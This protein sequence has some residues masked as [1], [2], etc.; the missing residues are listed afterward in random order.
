MSA[1]GRLHP[2]R[3]VSMRCAHRQATWQLWNVSQGSDSCHEASFAPF[4]MQQPGPASGRPNAGLADGAGADPS[5]DVSRRAGSR[6]TSARARTGSPRSARAPTS[7]S[8]CTIY[9]R[10]N[11]T[12][13]PGSPRRASRRCRPRAGRMQLSR[14]MPLQTPLAMRT[15]RRRTARMAG[16]NCPRTA[17]DCAVREVVRALGQM[18]VNRTAQ[19]CNF[20]NATIGCMAEPAAE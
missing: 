8:A 18:A 3:G 5:A 11:R 1:V 20:C 17:S 10:A 13:P 16:M 7:L 4:C 9:R 12:T 2:T 14:R 6:G 15:S 19:H